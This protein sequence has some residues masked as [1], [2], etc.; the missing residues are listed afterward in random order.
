MTVSAV[1]AIAWLALSVLVLN[2]GTVGAGIY[3]GLSIGIW[4]VGIFY[5]IGGKSKLEITAAEMKPDFAVWGEI[6]KIGFPFFVTQIGT[7][8]YNVVAANAIGAVSG[9][10]ASLYIGAFGVISGYIVYILKFNLT[11][12]RVRR[13]LK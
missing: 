8:I 2:M 3:Y 9:E 6:F 11:M 5:F 13:Q 10:N 7:F 1:I 12:R 4:S